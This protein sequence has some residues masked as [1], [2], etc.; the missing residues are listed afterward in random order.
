MLVRPE[1]RWPA[2]GAIVVGAAEGHAGGGG[3]S[4][5]DPYRF[6]EPCAAKVG[7][8]KIGV[9]EAATPFDV[10]PNRQL[11]PRRRPPLLVLLLF[12]RRAFV[13]GLACDALKA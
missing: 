12:T 8:P 6:D 9:V 1:P 3:G 7:A 2:L 10:C 4:L 13:G 5:G 11:L